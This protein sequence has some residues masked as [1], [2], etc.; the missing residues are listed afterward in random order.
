MQMKKLNI[1]VVMLLI[2]VSAI[3]PARA[4]Q[5][6]AKHEEHKGKTRQTTEATAEEAT[7][8][9]TEAPKQSYSLYD[10]QLLAQIIAAEAGADYVSHNTRLYVGSVVLNR[11]N[12]PLF[13]DTVEGVLWQPGQY[14][15]CITDTFWSFEPSDDCKQVAEYLLT[16]GS[17]LPANVLYQAN[18]RQGSGVFC[19][20]DTIYFCYQ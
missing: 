8:T 9:T 3:V 6:M 16:H 20:S 2:V 5:E 10:Y 19:E 17:V 15:S 13:P 7:E 1:I 11:V 14:Y 4:S 18:F 12:S